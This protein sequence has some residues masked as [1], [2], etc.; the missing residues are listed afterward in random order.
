MFSISFEHLTRPLSLEPVEVLKSPEP[1]RAPSGSE[2]FE[3]H[4][5]PAPRSAPSS[6]A[7]ARPS[8]PQTPHATADSAQAAARVDTDDAAH[9]EPE[10]GG[11]TETDSAAIS[12]TEKD[13]QDPSERDERELVSE[14]PPSLPALQEPSSPSP[15]DEASDAAAEV[16]ESRSNAPIERLIETKQEAERGAPTERLATEGQLPEQAVEVEATERLPSKLQV[17]ESEGG[18]GLQPKSNAEAAMEPSP[19]VPSRASAEAE[20]GSDLAKPTAT[21]LGRGRESRR[22]SAAPIVPPEIA[23]LLGALEAASGEQA[24]AVTRREAADGGDQAPLPTTEATPGR[25]A[26]PG[27]AS[28]P[29][30][31]AQQLLPRGTERH[32]RGVPLTEPQQARFVERVAR[33]FQAAEGRGGTLRLRLSPPELGSL[34]L[35]VRV[36]GGALH[37]KI[38]ADNPVARALLLENLPALRERLEE[39]G[40]RV[41]QFDVGLLD[42]QTSGSPNG[43]G[44]SHREEQPSP[45]RAPSRLKNETV[46]QTREEPPSLAGDDRQLNVVV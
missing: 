9:T 22:E 26:D 46:E 43:A 13:P 30:R 10:Q 41:N 17:E 15:A 11:E 40:V 29:P 6:E 45:E 18:G 33:A 37:A 32:D 2:S 38:E 36:Q 5:R 8:E 4:L 25:E 35:E 16:R 19:V 31:F 34:R 28:A 3:S 7:D 21:Q 44:Y 42:R 27:A 24:A 14:T 20:S 23:K 12:T 1:D 39:H